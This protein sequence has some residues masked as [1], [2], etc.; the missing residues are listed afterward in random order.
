M[1]NKTKILSIINKKHR[2]LKLVF[3]VLATLIVSINYNLILAPNRFV[4]GGMSG[5]AIIVNE[6]TGL[7]RIAFLY[8][9]TGVLFLL[10]LVL[11]DKKTAFKSLFGSLTFNLMVGLTAP[12]ENLITL[13]YQSTFLLLLLSG[14][15]M[16]IG[17]GFIYRSTYN[18]GG[19]DVLITIINK[20]GKITMGKASNIVNI[21][22]I[23][24]GFLIFG[25]TNTLYAAMTLILS[26]Y[27]TDRILLGV[28]DSKMIYIKSNNSLKLSEYIMQKFSVGVTEMT[29]RGGFLTKKSPVLLVIVPTRQYY[30]FRHSITN[31]DKNAFVLSIDC[32][33]VSGGFKKGLIPF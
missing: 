15:L 8:I 1:R 22:I 11:L 32:Y 33:G 18:T 27:I 3:F 21:I 31:F 12:L 6:L 26:N 23:S 30:R 17:T 29:S 16:G 19:S 13:N 5:V 9:A 7:S 20:Y 25:L 14:T 4:V 10:S 2:I 28:K 24:G